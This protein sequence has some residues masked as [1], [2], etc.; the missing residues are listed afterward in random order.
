MAIWSRF[1]LALK[2]LTNQR[3][4]QELEIW[5]KEEGKWKEFLTSDGEFKPSTVAA[6]LELVDTKGW[7][8]L[9]AYLQNSMQT[10][11]MENLHQ[12]EINVN[13][14][15][16]RTDL[17]LKQTYQAGTVRGAALVLGFPLYVQS[18]YKL[19]E[20]IQENNQ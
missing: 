3:Q 14:E 17:T 13:S 16:P 19:P 7:E 1:R 9:T 8:I 6:V 2:V 18:H 12:F 11:A 5:F 15:K 20:Q 10:L 4:Y